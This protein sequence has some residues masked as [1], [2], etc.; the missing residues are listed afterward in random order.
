MS[1]GAT[2]VNKQ[3]LCR[4]WDLPAG[5][6][7]ATWLVRMCFCVKGSVIDESAVSGSSGRHGLNGG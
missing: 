5:V 3:C 2:A 1:E 6:G 7:L 4:Q